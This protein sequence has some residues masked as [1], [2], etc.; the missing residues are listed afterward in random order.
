M[1]G[2]ELRELLGRVHPGV[3]TLGYG[4]DE[5]PCLEVDGGRFGSIMAAVAGRPVSVETGLNILEDGA[6]HV[7]VEVSLAFSGTGMREEFL[8]NAAESLRFFE[9]LASTSMLALAP[10]G[11]SGGNV[12]MVQLPRPERARGALD[13]IRRG[14]ARGGNGC[15]R[16]DSDPG[17]QLGKLE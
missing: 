11:A 14:L 17:H 1:A 15:S 12:F 8:V 3:T 4:R 5:V 9:L 13:M 10:P 16:R 6:G 7:F 2:D